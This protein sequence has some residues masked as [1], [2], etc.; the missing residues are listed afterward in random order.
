MNMPIFG[1]PLALPQVQKVGNHEHSFL[2]HFT[3]VSGLLCSYASNVTYD[4]SSNLFI[5]LF[6][7]ESKFYFSNI[8]FLFLCSSISPEL[9]YSGEYKTHGTREW[10]AFSYQT[11]NI[12]GRRLPALRTR[13]LGCNDIRALGADTQDNVIKFHDFQ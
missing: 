6:D 10:T 1:E 13:L 11:Q 8:Y 7:Y 12:V 5:V 2:K 3:S 9:F 4:S